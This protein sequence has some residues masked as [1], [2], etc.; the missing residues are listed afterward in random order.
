MTQVTA[1]PRLHITLLDLGHSTLAAYGGAGFT[2]SE[3]RTVV[4]AIPA[5]TNSV[6][7]AG[8][9]TEGLRG[10]LDRL[11]A[12]SRKAASV[13]VLKTPDCHIGFGST[14]SLRLACL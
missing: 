13:T 9:D 7:G 1:Y 10:A 5:M 12:E 11:S 4:E 2:M 6:V 8:D 14:T 3:P